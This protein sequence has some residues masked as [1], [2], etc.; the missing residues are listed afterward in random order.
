[1][2]RT[3]WIAL[4]VVLV[5]LSACRHHQQDEDQPAATPSAPVMVSVVNNFALPVEIFA[6]G[7]GTVVRLGTVHPGMTASFV[8]P[9]SVLATTTIE[10]EARSSSTSRVGRSGPLILA[11]GS[12]VDFT[13]TSTM[14]NSTANIRE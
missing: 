9:H 7:S 8:V 5:T 3:M 6:R 11:P 10:L 13:V 14:F 12:N 4:A 2:R 1:M